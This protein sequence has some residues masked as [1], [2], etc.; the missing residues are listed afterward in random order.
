MIVFHYCS[1]ETL[2]NI[3]ASKHLWL[4][5]LT[6]SNDSQEVT[7]TFQNLW[8]R[9]KER[10]IIS[11]LD[12]ETVNRVIEILD[13]QYKLEVVIDLPFGCCFC[14]DWDILQQWLVYGDQTKGV[15]LGF[16]LD[17]FSDID[18][19]MPHRSMYVSHSIGYHDILYHTEELDNAFYQ[20][21][22][23]AVKDHG[24]EAWIRVIRTTF[25]HYSAFIKNPTFCGEYEM[26]IIYYPADDHDLTNSSLNISGPFG[27]QSKHY[28]L[29]WTKGKG[30]HAL[31]AIGLGCNCELDAENLK[32]MLEEAGISGR[33][34]LLQSQCSYRL[35]AMND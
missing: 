26:R 12:Q 8:H 33:F 3:L 35:R 32:Q 31:C 10:L 25:K 7:R 20:I 13:Q 16:E 4:S 2:K 1:V 29:P 6:K 27:D 5:D 30:D 9:V 14:K 23:D 19:K 15:V 24:L 18:Y 34:D 28:C 17:W 21:C 11:D 22:Y